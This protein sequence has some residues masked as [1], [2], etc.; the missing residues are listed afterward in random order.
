MSVEET[1]KGQK[2]V[3]TL[4][5]TNAIGDYCCKR[6]REGFAPNTEKTTGDL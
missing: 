5:K 2:R 6:E 1:G 4:F 3:K